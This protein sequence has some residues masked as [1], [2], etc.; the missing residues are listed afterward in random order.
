MSLSNPLSHRLLKDLGTLS[1]L[2]ERGLI[3]DRHFETI[4][5]HVKAGNSAAKERWD[6]IESA[7]GLKQKGVFNEKEWITQLDGEIQ[8]ITSSTQLSFSSQ[9]DTG[10]ARD[11][12]SQHSPPAA[13]AAGKRKVA[14][15]GKQARER[16]TKGSLGGNIYNAFAIGSGQPVSSFIRRTQLLL[17]FTS[18][19]RRNKNRRRD[20]KQV[21]ILVHIYKCI[22]YY[23]TACTSYMYST[24]RCCRF[25]VGD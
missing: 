24:S 15:R 18:V 23:S 8:G 13:A 17:L 1:E 19:F 6:A 12:P 5:A 21:L 4:K 14:D 22:L 16:A 3:L 20:K 7:W 11:V 9:R 25:D 2:K 10:G